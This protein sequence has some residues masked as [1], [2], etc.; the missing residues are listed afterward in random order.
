MSS[1]DDFLA[2]DDEPVALQVSLAG[3]PW[4]I[5]VV[6]DDTDVHEATR[7]ALGGLSILERPLL[8][9]HAYSAAEALDL[10]QRERD[11]AAILLDVVMES[12]SAGLDAVV[13]IREDLGLTNTRIILRTGQ[14]GYAPEIDTIRRY[15]INDYKTK[16]ELTR[17][18]LY[19][20]LSTALRTYD[21]LCRIDESR[22]GL[23][24]ILSASHR[25]MEVS[26]LQGFCNAVL[27]Q[28]SQ[29]LGVPADGLVCEGESSGTAGAMSVLAGVGRYAGREGQ[30]LSDAASAVARDTIALSLERRRNTV[31]PQGV[32]VYLSA[33]KPRVVIGFL[34]IDQPIEPNPMLLDVFSTNI[35]LNGNIVRLIEKLRA[36]AF[37]DG[38][39]GLPNRTA[40]IEALEQHMS[41]EG[42]AR[43]VLALIDIDQ[44]AAINDLF[45]HRYGDSLLTAVGKRLR[46]HLSPACFVARISNDI[47]AVLGPEGEAQPS[48]LRRLFAQPFLFDDAE[49]VISVCIGSLRLSES[50]G[51]GG[52]CLKDAWI[53]IKHAKERGQ[54][55]LAWYSA[56]IGQVTRDHARLLHALR[57]AFKSERLFVAY[58][59]QLEFGSG[60]VV[61][62]EALLRWR[63]D[64]GQFVSPADFVPIA[65]SSG[66]IVPLGEWVLRRSLA[67]VKEMRAAGHPD[68]HVAVNVSVVQFGHP[69]FIEMVDKAL[70]ESGMP[71][72]ALE[73]EITESVAIMGAEAVEAHLNALR[74]RGIAIAL[75]DFGTGFSSLSYLDRLPADRIKI[76]RSFVNALDSGERG[77]RIAEMVI[78]L[79]KRL[80]MIVLAEGVE[81]EAQAARLIELGCQEAQGFLYAKPMP[82]PDLLTWLAARRAGAA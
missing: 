61:G 63:T 4:R 16:N 21:Q 37:V 11:I 41:G 43:T 49:H 52:D 1:A 19:A 81:T 44:F 82:L 42:A 36:T 23:E 77:A 79:G 28:L 20:T 26:D 59:P 66:L 39:T 34:H 35:T 45:G 47:F 68:M 24:Y 58:Q 46:E 38:L 60:R 7:L 78:P 65:E 2:F 10:L 12:Q 71:S 70:A 53:A 54:N 76:D 64:E 74:G 56:E 69:G 75:D 14:P 18:K 73:L 8:L 3:P 30:V 31:E 72:S 55:Q 40:L 27:A 17:S 57:D 51:N 6:D 15:D 48:S 67:A 13:R 80:D 62:A 9:L 32:A 5:L 29:F 50:A 22:R 33:D 25:L